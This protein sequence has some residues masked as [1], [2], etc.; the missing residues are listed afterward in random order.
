VPE[1]LESPEPYWADE[2]VRLY[3]GKCEEILP[4][5]PANSV[6]SIVTDPPYGLEFM[7]A[8]WDTFRTGDGF[9]RSRNEA[10]AGRDSVFGRTSRTAPE[11]S[12]G[13]LGKQPKIGEADGSKFR[14]NM[15]TPSYTGSG[16]PTCRNCGGDKYRNGERKCQCE[17]PDFGNPA[18]VQMNA[19]Q[20][21]CEQ[22]ARECL[23]VLKPG[24]WMLAFGSS[25]TS[26]RLKCGIEDAGFEIRDT[27]AELTGRDAPEM[28]W[29]YGQGMP[30][31][32]DAAR[33]V[34]M[35]V[36][37]LPGKHCMRRVPDDPKPGDH[38]CPESEEGLQWKGWG[39]ALAPAWEPVVVARKPLAGT[40]GANLLAYGTGAVNVDGCR[41]GDDTARADRYHGKPA[42]GRSEG[43]RFGQRAEPWVPPAGRWPSNVVLVHSADC[44][45]AGLRAVHGDNRK[46]GT[47]Q[48]PGGF[49]SIGADTG[50]TAPNGPLYGDAEV[51]VWDCAEGCPVA[52]L[53]R[54]S[55]VLTSGTGAVKRA[56]AKGGAQSASI[57]AES[58]A[59]GTP[60]LSYGDS[61]GA[62]RFFKVFKYQAKATSA[63]RP[64]LPDGTA[65]PTVK[66][67][68]LICWLVVLVTPPGG[69]V[70]DLFAGTGP[71]G[72][73][74]VIEG[75][76]CILIDKDPDAAEL[77]KTRLSK[78]IQ[79]AMLT[80]DDSAQP[81]RPHPVAAAS[82]PKPPPEAHPSLFDDLDAAS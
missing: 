82:R 43:Y 6:D 11:Y 75:F 71:V 22:W 15:G 49:L 21:W 12:T 45:P 17:A 53:D 16:N 77:T 10:D 9:R 33:A 62:S 37:T 5:L 25:R 30:K 18:V 70:L 35:T 73:A 44:R 55:G 52:G 40:L 3:L 60:M 34:D 47:G 14:Q 46:G 42:D 4:S 13:R 81:A 63:E 57:G 7:G 23:R 27:V 79:P 76:P 41:V 80:V 58:R 1:A 8:E 28:M 64:K 50:D 48:R 39:T 61:G 56:S 54:Q 20:V 69:T 59:E 65:W 19:F 66:P 24:G 72:E 74:C 2:D 51:E 36:C 78:P 32:F 38:V 29:V 68:P 26:H 67:L 31:S